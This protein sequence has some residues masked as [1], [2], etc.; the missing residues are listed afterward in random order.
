LWAAWLPPV[1]V[2]ALQPPVAA[3]RQDDEQNDRDRDHNRP[4]HRQ[5]GPE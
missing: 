3:R 4:A 5:R 1:A 2:L